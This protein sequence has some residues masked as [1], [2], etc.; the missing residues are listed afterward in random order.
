VRELIDSGVITRSL[1]ELERTLR[2]LRALS[3]S[4]DDQIAPELA[5]TL[6]EA[7]RALASANALIQPDAPLNV[8]AVRAMRELSEAARSIRVMADYLQRHPEAL[9]KGK[10]GGR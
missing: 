5:E 10:G 4:L 1:D 9:I 2:E 3:A 7:R 6:T 8:E